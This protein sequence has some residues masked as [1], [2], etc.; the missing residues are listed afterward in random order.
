[1]DNMEEKETS[2]PAPDVREST[3][4]EQLNDFTVNTNPA[5]DFFNFI[6][7]LVK[8]GLVVFVIA[9]ALR[10][11]AIQPFVVDG[12][13]MMPNFVNNEYLLAEKISYLISEPK[14]GD[15]IVFKYPKNPSVNY[16]KRIIGL[17]GE[18][19]KVE[20]EKIIIVSGDFPNGIILSEDYIPS[21]YQISNRSNATTSI[22]L[23]KDEFFVL[24][25]NRQHSSDSREWGILPRANI[26]GRAWVTLLPFDRFGLQHR[27]SYQVQY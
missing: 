8:T 18:T 7:D 11:F 24:G 26:T 13:S 25:D 10:Y 22:T 12:E 5:K 3:N 16:I 23:G 6:L 27:K 19:V 15:V 1:M 14:R 4:S 17:P 20:K 2:T 21:D 9:F